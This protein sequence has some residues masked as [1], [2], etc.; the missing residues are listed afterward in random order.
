MLMS[1]SPTAILNRRA[2]GPPVQCPHLAVGCHGV[3][4]NLGKGKPIYRKNST[5]HIL[6]LHRGCDCKYRSQMRIQEI[7]ADDGQDEDGDEPM[8][9]EEEAA[10][11]AA[12]GLDSNGVQLTDEQRR[13]L[14]AKRKAESPQSGT[15]VKAEGDANQLDGDGAA[16]SSTSQPHYLTSDGRKRVKTMLVKGNTP[17]PRNQPKTERTVTLSMKKWRNVELKMLTMEERQVQVIQGAGLGA[18][19]AAATQ[20]TAAGGEGSAAHHAVSQHSQHSRCSCGCTR[21]RQ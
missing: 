5:K 6:A 10:A 17:Q 13:M 7:Q 8:T 9:A 20:H 1:P 19:T 14:Y 15:G 3:C 4:P 12:A 11:A 16:A 18:D 21:E 2:S